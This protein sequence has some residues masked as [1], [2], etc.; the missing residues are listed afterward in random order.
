MLDQHPDVDEVLIM[1]APGH[2]DAVREIVQSGGYSK[3]CAILEG[4]QTRNNQQTRSDHLGDEECNVLFHDAVRPLLALR[5]VRLLP[6]ARNVRRGRRRFR[7]P[8]PSSGDL[9]QHHSLHTA[10]PT[11]D[12]VRRL[13]RSARPSSRRR[14]TASPDRTSSPPI[15]PSCCDIYPSADLRIPVRTAT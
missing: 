3:V 7:R 1:M 10:A 2:L 9:R 4:A 15:A 6:C 11:C 12:A 5:I 8:T 14:T 13:R